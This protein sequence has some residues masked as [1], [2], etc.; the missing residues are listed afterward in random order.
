MV[1]MSGLVTDGSDGDSDLGLV[2]DG[3]DWFSDRW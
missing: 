3:D 2:T 1:V